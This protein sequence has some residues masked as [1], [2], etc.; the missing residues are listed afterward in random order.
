VRTFFSKKLVERTVRSPRAQCAFAILALV[1]VRLYLAAIVPLS[2]DESYYWTWSRN[3]AGG[4]FDHP[5]AVAVLIRLGTALFGNNEFGVRLFSVLL[6]LPTTWAVWQ[7][8]LTLFEDERIAAT[9]ALYLNLSLVMSVGSA[10]AT[11]DNPLVAAAA[12]LMLGLTKLYVTKRKEYWL[13]IGVIFGL[14]LLSKYTM[15]F[16]AVSILSWLLVVPELRRWLR[17][18]WP[19]LSGVV[20]LM[21]FSPTLIWNYRHGWVSFVYTYSRRLEALGW[22]PHYFGE[23][24]LGQFGLVL[25]PIFILG[26]VGLIAFWRGQ[27]GSLAARALIWALVGPIAL[28][29]TWYSLHERVEG[30]WPEPIYV[31]FVIAAAVAADRIKL[32][33]RWESIRSWS[34]HSVLPFSA[35]VVALIYAQ[36]AFVLIPLGRRDPIERMLGEGWPE[37]SVQIDS[38]RA[39]IG[40][41]VILT[42]GDQGLVGWLSFYLPSGTPIEQIDVRARFVNGPPPDSALFRGTMMF[43][44]E[45][46]CGP[47]PQWLQ[48]RFKSVEQ[49]A[50]LARSSHGV[51]IRYYDVFRVSD[52]LVPVL[53]PVRYSDATSVMVKH[54]AHG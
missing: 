26:V 48:G 40:A 12:L 54:S 11:P 2:F 37:L 6:G 45:E 51:A 33:G 28:Y 17:T 21:V 20:A 39:Q 25:P 49:V 23:F 44:C 36:A 52:P 29:M 32:A 7:V 5:P 41:P 38:L 22:N 19:Y 9:A 8:A 24:A 53:D 18:P 16:F 34:R 4:Y 50:R 30:N 14:G 31:S 46:D 10:L 35:V 27:G 47:D 15:I 3:L 42:Q 43:I 13:L 1:C